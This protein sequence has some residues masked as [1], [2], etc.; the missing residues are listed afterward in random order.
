MFDFIKIIFLSIIFIFIGHQIIK[1][2]KAN[3][4]DTNA[5]K[6]MLKETRKMYED[7]AYTL[8]LSNTQTK[9]PNKKGNNVKI[10]EETNTINEIPNRYQQLS[11]TNI[12]DLE[13]LSQNTNQFFDQNINN[14][15]DELTSYMNTLSQ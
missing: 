15:Q 5:T 1:Y 7:I 12:E 2:I 3:Y 4:I 13:Y 10:N 6:N 9:Y 8:N 11:T 14:M